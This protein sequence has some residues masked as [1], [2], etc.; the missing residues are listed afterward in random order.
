MVFFIGIF[1]VFVLEFLYMVMVLE[2]DDKY[3]NEY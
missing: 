1:C 3:I 2:F